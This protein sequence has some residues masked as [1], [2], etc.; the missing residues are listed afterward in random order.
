MRIVRNILLLFALVL[1]FNVTANEAQK[2]EPMNV[3]EFILHHVADS[4]GWHIT[5]FKGHEI[6]IP[7]PVI[8]RGE[9]G[10]WFIFS[11]ARL[12]NNKNYK[13]FYISHEEKYVGKIVE[14]NAQGEEVRPLDL[15]FTKNACGILISSI[16]LLSIFLVTAR[17]FKRKPLE[18][19]R[20]IVGLMEI[21]ILNIENEIAKPCIGKTHRKYTPYLLTLFFF[22]F[23]NDI[24]GLI[25]IFPG[26]ANITGNIAITFT[27]AVITMLIVN[28]GGS[29][30]YWREI[31]WPDVPIWLKIPPIIPIIEIVGIFT[32]PFALMI[33][34]FASIFAGHAII[35]GLTSLIFISASMGIAIS[36]SMTILSI[37]FSVFISFVELLV[38]YFQAYIFT[39]LTAV[40][41]GLARVEPHHAK[42]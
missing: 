24:L 39:L 42:H 27:L 6:S 5:K 4:Y 8:V 25:P 2:G 11:S 41:I 3:R 37:L 38:G 29:K 28:I 15:S 18:A 34:L 31:L 21:L 17:S 35:L 26:G 1:S 40:F 33:R 16:I 14:K 19:K 23:L 7:L 9:N 32:K 20:G 12:H 30:E 10:N 22:I 13:G 36:S